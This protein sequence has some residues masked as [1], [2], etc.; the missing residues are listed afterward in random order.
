MDRPAATKRALAS[1]GGTLA[2]SYYACG[3]TDVSIIAD[4]PDNT[5]AASL[6]LVVSATEAIN[7]ETAVLLTP[8][9]LDDATTRRP[10]VPRP[11]RRL[12]AR[13]RHWAGARRRDL[14][15]FR[16]GNTE[17]SGD[18]PRRTHGHVHD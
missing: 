1:V 14:L 16:T 7:G 18:D 17:R 15:Q 5:A 12:R 3:E 6:S 2:A 10:G 9:E 8:D 13:Q 4:L 11:E